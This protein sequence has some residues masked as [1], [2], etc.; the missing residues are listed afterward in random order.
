TLFRS[1]SADCA[2]PQPCPADKKDVVR[3]TNPQPRLRRLAHAL[4][5]LRFV[6][7]PALAPAFALLWGEEG[8]GHEAALLLPLGHGRDAHIAGAQG[9]QA[10]FQRRQD[11]KS[12][13]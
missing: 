1:L 10:G 11:R 12:V 4:I 3:P 5:T 6:G 7:L 2:R 13:V 8:P 9:L